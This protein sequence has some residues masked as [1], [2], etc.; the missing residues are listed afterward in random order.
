MLLFWNVYTLETK[1]KLWIHL[2]DGTN[3]FNF[4]EKMWLFQR[5]QPISNKEDSYESQSQQKLEVFL[6]NFIYKRQQRKP[7]AEQS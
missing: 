1:Q 3:R 2:E 6:L 7:E 5:L 4:S